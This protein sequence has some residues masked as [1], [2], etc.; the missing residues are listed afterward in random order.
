LTD[1]NACERTWEGS[2]RV[3]SFVLWSKAANWRGNFPPFLRKRRIFSA[4]FQLEIAGGELL[5]PRIADER[6]GVVFVGLVLHES[7]V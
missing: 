5:G 2:S 6:E 7:T 1:L 3:R 4:R